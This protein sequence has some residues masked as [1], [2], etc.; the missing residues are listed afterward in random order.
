V[1]QKKGNSAFGKRRKRRTR[2]EPKAS[3]CYRPFRSAREGRESSSKEIKLT[4]S[5]KTRQHGLKAI[6]LRLQ[7]AKAPRASNKIKVPKLPCHLPSSANV[8]ISAKFTAAS[9]QVGPECLG[10]GLNRPRSGI[11]ERRH[12][13]ILPE[14]CHFLNSSLGPVAIIRPTSISNK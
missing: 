14:P 11:A 5:S 12:P 9:F 13:A 10:I 7:A 6:S 2:Q 8:V 3:H 4:A 1:P